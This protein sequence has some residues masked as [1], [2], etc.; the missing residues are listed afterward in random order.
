[1]KLTK[2]HLYSC[3][4]IKAMFLHYLYFFYQDKTCDHTP[5]A[6]TSRITTAGCCGDW[7]MMMRRSIE[8][9]EMFKMVI[10]TAGYFCTESII[11]SKFQIQFILARW[12]VVYPDN[13]LYTVNNYLQI[14]RPVHPGKVDC[15][16][17]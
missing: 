13:V 16:L 17:F 7:R 12:I 1:M 4:R 3:T 8:A 11:T 6:A 5:S 9:S 15:C 14:S 10:T 2:F